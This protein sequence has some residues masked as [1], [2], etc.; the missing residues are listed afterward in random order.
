[1][2]LRFAVV[3]CCPDLSNSRASPRRTPGAPGESP[4]ENVRFRDARTPYFQNVSRAR[5]DDDRRRATTKA[6]DL[7]REFASRKRAFA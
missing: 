3:R 6:R 1:V 2:L 5:T 4:I 7:D